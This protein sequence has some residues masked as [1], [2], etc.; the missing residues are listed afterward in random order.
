MFFIL[1]KIFYFLLMPI[2]WIVLCLILGLLLKK[3]RLKM[4]FLWLGFAQ[5]IFF[6]NPFILN[7]I[8]N[9]WEI[10]A[11]PI[12]SLINYDVAIVLTGVTSDQKPRDRVNYRRGAD[13]VLHTIHLYKI[14]KV[15]KILV[16]GGSGSVLNSN[17][18]IESE[19]IKQTLLL[20]GIPEENIILE[21]K[22]KNTHENAL[23]SHP[24][25]QKQFPGQSYLLVTSAFHMRRAYACFKKE[26]INTTP[27]P[28][29]FY[30][31]ERVL[32]PDKFLPDAEPMMAWKILIKEWVGIIA[33]KITG[34][35]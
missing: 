9:K 8:V 21:T 18:D 6:S 20:A 28:V 24:I 10:K 1:S 35:I 2:T 27:F 12:K 17:E 23:F 3:G 15:K 5:L 30:S 33:Y 26:G 14:G 25:L 34:Y 29:D 31:E 16:T 11:I 32:T 22:A 19:N 4:L 7:E 13:R